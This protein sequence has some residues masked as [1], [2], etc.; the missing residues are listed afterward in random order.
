MPFALAIFALALFVVL[1]TS[2]TTR[3]RRS[4]RGR[5]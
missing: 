3:M 1:W 4:K 5:K 2:A